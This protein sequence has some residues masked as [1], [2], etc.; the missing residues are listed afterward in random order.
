MAAAISDILSQ[1]WTSW[2]VRAD[3]PAMTFEPLIMARPSRAWRTSGVMPARLRASAPG[4][5]SPL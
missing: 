3:M 1:R 4:R 2:T 5:R